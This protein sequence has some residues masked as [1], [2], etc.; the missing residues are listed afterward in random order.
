ML[1]IVFGRNN[2]QAIVNFPFGFVRAV[3]LAPT[4]III[5]LFRH[6]ME[7]VCACVRV[8]P[9]AMDGHSK[10]LLIWSANDVHHR[11]VCAFRIPNRPVL[12][13]K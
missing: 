8:C 11:A 10:K 9:L 5:L 7:C 3:S 12:A 1:L 2:L 6:I 4:I 13:R